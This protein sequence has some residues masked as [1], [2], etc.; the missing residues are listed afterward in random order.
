MT[1]FDAPKIVQMLDRKLANGTTLYIATD[2]RDKSFFDPIRQRYDAVF[3]DDFVH[4]LEGVNSKSKRTVDR[5]LKRDTVFDV[6]LL[7]RLEIVANYYGMIGMYFKE[8]G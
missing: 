1:R 5:L 4:E 6:S 2:E 3:L 7:T 8:I